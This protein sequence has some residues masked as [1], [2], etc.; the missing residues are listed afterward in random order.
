[1]VCIPLFW[2]LNHSPRSLV[3]DNGFF[4]HKEVENKKL[5]TFAN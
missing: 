5:I 1:M 2:N 4:F 3:K